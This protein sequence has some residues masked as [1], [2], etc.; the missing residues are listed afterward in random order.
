MCNGM[1]DVA[2]KCVSLASK[3][4]M[5]TETYEELHVLSSVF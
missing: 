5:G 1:P 4:N 2:L 3:W